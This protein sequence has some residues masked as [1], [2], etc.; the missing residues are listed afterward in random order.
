MKRVTLLGATG[1][2]GQ[3]TLDIIA[4]H[5]DDYS[6]FALTANSSE[7]PMEALCRRFVPSF[8]VMGDDAS[9]QRLQQSLA[10]L[11]TRVLSGDD[12]LAR[13]AAA[14]QVDVVVAAI[15]GAVGLLP[16]LGGA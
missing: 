11:P 9:A 12:G 6:L 10:D 15:V 2:I 8:A 14:E 3:S 13:V 4:R 1:S 16:T 5:P 7:A